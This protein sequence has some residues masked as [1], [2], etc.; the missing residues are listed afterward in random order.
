MAGEWASATFQY[1]PPGQSHTF[2]YVMDKL[3]NALVMSGWGRPSWDGGA[4]GPGTVGTPSTPASGD[5]RYFIRTDRA[6][7]GRWRFTGDLLTQH[8]GILVWYN[9]DAGVDQGNG[10]EPNLGGPSNAGFSGPMIVIQTFLENSAGTGAQVLTPDH[11]EQANGE[12][13]T[14]SVRI[15]LDNLAVNNYLV[16]VGEDGLY[17]ESGRDSRYN[18]LGHGAVMTFGVIPELHGTRD[19]AV[20]W[21][22]QGLVADFSGRCRF[23]DDRDRRFVT[24]DG[25]DKNFTAALAPL[26]PRGTSDI[27]TTSTLVEDQRPYYIGARDN[28]LSAGYGSSSATGQD[29]GTSGAGHGWL[30]ASTF[31]LINTPKDDR[32]RLSPLFMIQQIFHQNAG[33]N[34]SSA[35]NNVAAAGN[36]LSLLDVRVLRQVFRF[37]AADYTLIPAV[38]VVDSVSG[39]T[40]RIVRMEDDGRFS[41]FGVEVPS[42]VLTLP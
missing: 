31:G 25:T 12:T 42:T 22:A 10:Y 39:A 32:I 37:A 7:Q 38:N 11:F 40:Y 8:G 6:T 17:I 1:D 13:R 34:S 19:E 35:S 29:M 27:D 16:Y 30:Y 24:N 3:E 20:Q 33:V 5:A 2:T 21:T 14:G 41:T 28:Y 4:F 26:S 9:A 23:S 15:Q 36:A 18:N